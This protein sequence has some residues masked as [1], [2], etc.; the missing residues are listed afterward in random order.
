MPEEE[1]EAEEEA[2]EVV[3]VVMVVAARCCS[4]VSARPQSSVPTLIDAS[5]TP[6]SCCTHPCLC[7]FGYATCKVI[8]SNLRNV[9][10]LPVLF[11]TCIVNNTCKKKQIS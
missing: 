2:A 1:E 6:R 7:S 9:L 10:Y 5:P 3:V 11:S 4:F 8:I